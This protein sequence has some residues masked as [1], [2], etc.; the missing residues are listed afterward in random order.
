MVSPFQRRDV[1]RDRRQ[2][3]EQD[4]PRG[5]G[6]HRRDT[7]YVPLAGVADLDFARL[8][9]CLRREVAELVVLGFV[10]E[11]ATQ[12]RDRPSRPATPAA[13]ATLPLEPGVLRH[14]RPRATKGAVALPPRGRQLA[15]QPAGTRLEQ[16][17]GR[18]LTED[19][20][21]VRL[22]ACRRG[23]GVDSRVVVAHGG[24][25][26]GQLVDSPR[27][28][29][30]SDL[31]EA[32]HPAPGRAPVE[33]H[34]GTR[35]HRR[36]DGSVRHRCGHGGLPSGGAVFTLVQRRLEEPEPDLRLGCFTAGCG[37]PLLDLYVPR[38]PN[39]GIGPE[40][41]TFTVRQGVR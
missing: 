37:N 13:Q 30:G 28:H 40:H 19:A 2:V 15:R 12:E 7:L 8:L 3:V 35:Q 33:R 22:R 36:L 27:V 16:G 20:E 24:L 39:A 4:R 17:Q 34:L 14:D 38:V 23:H 21:G 26:Q 29:R 10:T 31:Q 5:E 1:Q 25:E 41:F 6:A 18:H 11:H 32:A 9:T